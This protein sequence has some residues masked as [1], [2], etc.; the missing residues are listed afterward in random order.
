MLP[1]LMVA[2]ASGYYFL[3]RLK[4][5]IKNFL[6]IDAWLNSEVHIVFCFLSQLKALLGWI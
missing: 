3:P 5:K 1:L 4:K 6:L 2:G